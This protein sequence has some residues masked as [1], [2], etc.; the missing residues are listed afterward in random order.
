MSFVDTVLAQVTNSA[1]LTNVT[2]AAGD[3]LTVRGFDSPA[4]C[5][6]DDII[7]KGGQVTT[8]RLTSPNLHDSTRGITVLTSQAPSE[9]TLPRYVTQSMRSQ[10][11][12]VF[13]GNSGAA[14]SSVFALQLYYEGSDG[15]SARLAHLGDLA[16]L[17]VNI[18]PLEIDCATSATIGQWADTSITVTDNLLS[19]NAD[20]ALLGLVVD[21][22]V[23]VVAIKGQDTGNL[24]IGVPGSALSFVTSE[25]FV[26]KSNDTGR[27]YIPIIN[28]ANANNTVISVAD[29][30]A[31][32]AVKVQLILA[33]LATKLNV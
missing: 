2:F 4:H 27:P 33:E 9:R 30:A 5:Y 14:N 6:L 13:Q 23:G 18:K 16:G 26:E 7:V 28:A 12:L 22:A 25:Y 1:A 31:S 29:N 32:T 11:N 21:T 19:A 20:Y 10:D 17:V 8:A 24:R 3:S 15:N